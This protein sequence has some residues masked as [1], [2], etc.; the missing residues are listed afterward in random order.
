MLHCMTPIGQQKQ[1][2]HDKEIELVQ[3]KVEVE[4]PGKGK[5]IQL[6]LGYTIIGCTSRMSLYHS[7]LPKGRR[8]VP[9]V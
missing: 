7:V 8:S 2:I 1:N 4:Q 5:S 6:P 9:H 3:A